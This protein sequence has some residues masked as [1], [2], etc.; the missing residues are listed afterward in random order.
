MH[1]QSFLVAKFIRDMGVENFSYL[2]GKEY[3]HRGVYE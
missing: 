3:C 2:S 1:A